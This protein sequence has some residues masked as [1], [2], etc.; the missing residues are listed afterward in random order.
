[1]KPTWSK[2]YSGP[3]YPIDPKKQ[4]KRDMAMACILVSEGVAISKQ[5]SKLMDWLLTKAEKLLD[6]DPSY[7]CTIK[8][9]NGEPVNILGHSCVLI[10]VDPGANNQTVIQFSNLND[11]YS[12][13]VVEPE[14][15]CV[16]IPQPMSIDDLND[17]LEDICE[18]FGTTLPPELKMKADPNYSQVANLI[19]MTAFNK[20]FP[21]K[22]PKCDCHICLGMTGPE[23]ATVFRHMRREA[24]LWTEDFQSRL[25]E[26]QVKER[27]I[28]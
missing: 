11:P 22:T 24:M 7:S 28:G 18:S 8:A 25:M 6:I 5:K 3:G 20:I 19:A 14:Y 16:M 4:D 12:F 27:Q 21:E 9:I 15:S 2:V 26:I 13:S 10:G 17:N 23:E 1:M